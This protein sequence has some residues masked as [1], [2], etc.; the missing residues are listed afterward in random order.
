M[1]CALLSYTYHVT[2]TKWHLWHDTFLH[3]FLYSKEKEKEK[4][5]NINN[6]LAVLPSYDRLPTDL[7]DISA[8]IDCLKMWLV[9]IKRFFQGL[10]IA[11]KTVRIV[12]ELVKI[13]LN[14]VCDTLYY[15]SICFGPQKKTLLFF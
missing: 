1:V 9:L 12:E 3:S 11:I 14:E 13:G 4:K 7:P 10:S 6:D 8:N 5:I 15:I 2:V